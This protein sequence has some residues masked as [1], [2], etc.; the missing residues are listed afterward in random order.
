[1][2]ALDQSR[3]RVTT[4][5]K[6]LGIIFVV[7]AFGSAAPVSAVAG[8]N[9]PGG[10]PH[11]QVIVHNDVPGSLQVRGHVQLGR[12]PGPHV[13]PDNL[14]AAINTCTSHCQT[15]AVALQVNLVNSDNTVFAPQNVAVAAN[16]GCDGCVAEAVALQYN[17]GVDDPIN[18]PPRVD[19]MV[20]QMKQEMAQVSAT[21]TT[22]DQAE[23]GMLNVIGQYE[24]LANYLVTARDTKVSPPAA[25][26]APATQPAQAPTSTTSAPQPAPAPTSTTPSPSP[27]PTPSPQPSPAA[28]PS[29]AP[30]PSPS[31]T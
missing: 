13:A 27:D 19:Q 8:D 3:A 23:A 26:P 6:A 7:A 21:S 1:V 30:E 4:F 5:V 11:N 29:A 22:L 15:L 17:I 24:D 18:V 9:L 28:T 10:G 20:A 2:T 31:P 14:A 16:G 12:V 25:A